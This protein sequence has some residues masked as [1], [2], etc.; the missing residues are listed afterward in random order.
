MMGGMMMGGGCGK[1]GMM[2]GGGPGHFG[3]KGGGMMMAGGPMPGYG[4]KG[5]LPGP[6]AFIGQQLQGTLTM[7]KDNWGWISCPH[8]GGDIFAHKEDLRNSGSPP[9]VGSRVA[10]IP[11]TD[12]Q[13]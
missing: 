13:G 8:F 7:W 3:G 1:G 10:F 11:G 4:G 9:A 6:Q 5:G 12:T 2:M